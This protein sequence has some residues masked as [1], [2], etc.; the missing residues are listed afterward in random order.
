ME[1]N[2]EIKD[3]KYE[4]LMQELT[5]IVAKMENPSTTLDEQLTSYE[6]GIEISNR[7]FEMLKSFEDRI[8]IINKDG[9]EEKFE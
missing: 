3:K 7:L 2:K 8:M 6:K 5:A 4:D 9:K 1:N